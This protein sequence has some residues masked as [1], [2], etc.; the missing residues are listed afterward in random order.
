LPSKTKPAG[1]NWAFVF[2]QKVSFQHSAS[3]QL[4]HLLTGVIANVA[5]PNR[6]CH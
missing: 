3:Q 4:F 1:I 6:A 5:N 2:K